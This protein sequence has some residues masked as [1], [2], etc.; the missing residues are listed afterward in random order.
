MRPQL[1]RLG[2]V[3]SVDGQLRYVTREGPQ[4][5]RSGVDPLVDAEDVTWFRCSK[6][7]TSPI[8]ARVR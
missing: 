5:V 2:V 1:S 4:R 3:N 7:E 8:L 6:P